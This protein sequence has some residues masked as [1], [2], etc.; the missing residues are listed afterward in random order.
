[1]DAARIDDL[2]NLSNLVRDGKATNRRTIARQ[3][4][5]RSTT[6]S[7]LV[8]EL[9]QH[10]I[11]IETMA[12]ARGKG[13][14]AA[15]L[16]FN[17]QRLGAVFITVTDQRLEASAVDLGLRVI[18]T[19][20]V[21]PNRDADNLVLGQCI[22]QLVRDTAALFAR[23]VQLCAVVCSLSGLLDAKRRT[24]CV[25]SRWPNM[26]NLDLGAELSGFAAPVWLIRNLDA[27]LG[28][29]LAREPDMSTEAVLLLHWGHGIGAAYATEGNVVNSTHGRFCEIGHW[30]LGNGR[31]VE[32]T[33]GNRDCLETVASLWS[34]GTQ[35]AKDV[36]SI[37]QSERQFA[38]AL[39][40]V[41]LGASVVLG[42]ALSE[43][44]RITAN[45]CRLLFPNRVILTGPFVQNPEVYTRFVVALEQAPILRSLDR[46][47]VTLGHESPE[48]EISGALARPF[49]TAFRNLLEGRELQASKAGLS[50]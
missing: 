37:D 11:L 50:Q 29:I 39:R 30:G 13:R 17:Q 31:G 45:L 21:A 26:R 3:L 38:V 47:R 24:W 23:D 42:T 19:L 34:I 9:V 14:P 33:C 43:M 36:P 2:I 32:C 41:D 4:G 49:A 46:I 44:I 10:D 27:E 25:S 6:V 20:T 16:S 7:E 18:G 8:G 22:R 40:Q 35:L 15:V 12:R 5:L 48:A 1:M 28:G